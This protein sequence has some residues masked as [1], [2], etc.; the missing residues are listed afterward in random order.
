MDS[1]AKKSW[2]AK[3]NKAIKR[4]VEAWEKYGGTKDDDPEPVSSAAD[5]VTVAH[6]AA[7]L[8]WEGRPP[9]EWDDEVEK[10]IERL[11]VTWEKYDATDDDPEAEEALNMAL[12][13]LAIVHAAATFDW[14][15]GPLK[16]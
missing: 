13:A 2:E 11:V 5:A 10:A 9:K 3:R 15:S 7:A 16:W 8:E 12:D 4:L 1:I 6:I 14:A